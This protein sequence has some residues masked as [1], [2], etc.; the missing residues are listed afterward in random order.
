MMLRKRDSLPAWRGS[1]FLCTR[2]GQRVKHLLLALPFLAW[3]FAFAYMPVFGWGYAFVKFSMAKG[4]LEMPF[5]G[6]E[7]F[8]KIW[9]ASSEVARVLRNTLVMSLLNILGSVLPVIFAVMINE[10]RGRRFRKLV[11][12]ATTLPHFISWIVVFG[13]SFAMFSNNGFLPRFLQSMGLDILPP[14]GLLGNVGTIWGLMLF[15]NVWKT[16]GWNAIIYLAAIS[17]IDPALYDAAEADG[18]NKFQKIWHITIPGIASTYIVLLLLQVSNL[19]NNGFEQ[20]F[21]FFNPLVAERLEVL[22]YYV[23]KLGMLIGDY[24]MSVAVG[25]FKSLISILLLFLVNRIS[26]HVRGDLIF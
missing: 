3:F 19:L 26:K 9:E 21:T 12:T 25:M 8:M 14:M 4:L 20:Y 23:Y 5:A 7:N 6:L 17:G 18:A 2:K 24:S 16:C 10:I 22:D 1:R 13:L 11:Q 15:L